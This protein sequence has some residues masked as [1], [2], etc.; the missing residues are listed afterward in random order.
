[1]VSLSFVNSANMKRLI[2]IL[3]ILTLL[4]GLRT[5]SDAENAEYIEYNYNSGDYEYFILTDG[6]AQISRYNGDE[7]TVYIPETINGIKVTA[8]GRQAFI[9]CQKLKHLIIPETL[10]R[11][12]DW[13]INACSS[14]ETV[15]L[16]DNLSYMGEN[17][18]AGCSKLTSIEISVENPFFAKID[19]ALFSKT[20]KRL[21][22]YPAGLAEEVYEIPQGVRIIGGSAFGGCHSLETV[23]IPESVT[24]IGDTAFMSCS[25][26]NSISIPDSVTSVGANPFTLCKNLET[27]DITPEQTYLAIIDH[28]LFSKPDKRLIAYP[29]TLQEES[30]RIPNGIL[31]VGDRAFDS[32]D[33]LAEISFPDS[34][35]Q[36]GFRAFYGATQL[37]HVVIPGRVESIGNMA[38]FRSG[39]EHVALPSG[40]RQLGDTAFGSCTELTSINIPDSQMVIG[41][42]PFSN[43]TSLTEFDVSESNPSLTVIEGALFSKDKKTLI[44]YP[45]TLLSES[46]SIPYGTVEIGGSAFSDCKNLNRV[47]IP[48]TVEFIGETAFLSSGVNDVTIPASV[49]YIGNNAFQTFNDIFFTVTRNSYAA[50]YCKTRGLKYT[51]VDANDWLLDSY[52][53]GTALIVNKVRYSPAQVN[54]YYGNEYLTM[55]NNYGSYLSYLGLDTSLGLAGLGDQESSMGDGGTWKDYFRD[56]AKNDIRQI[57]ALLD[58]AAEYGITLSEEEIAEVNKSF[59]GM[60]E[61]AKS[62][63][64]ASADEF[65]T[66]NY[67]VGVTTKIAWQ[68]ALDQALASKAYNEKQD[69]LS[70]TAEELEEYYQGLNGDRDLFDYEIYYVSAQTEETVTDEEGNET[71][72]AVANGE[73]RAEA[74]A[75]ADAIVMAYKDGDDIENTAERFDAAVSSQVEGAVPTPRSDYYG[76]NIPEEYAEWVKDTARQEGDIEVFA[77]AEEEASGYTVVLYLDRNDNHY[78]TANVRHILIKAEADE[79]GNYTDEAKEAAKARA[80]EILAEFEAGEKTEDSFAALAEQYSEDEGSNTNGGLYENIYQGQMVTEFNDFCFGGHEPGDTGIVYGESGS[81]AGYHVIYYVGDG[82]LYSDYL[83]E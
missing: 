69:S 80:E 76:S 20:D 47:V 33:K 68:A 7:E 16:P 71:V 77:D 54:Y 64:Y 5:S 74:K 65:Y 50:E 61:T 1:M 23:I 49:I 60:D 58:Y 39:L 75:A 78:P 67:G 36:I 12:D 70:W 48:E 53:T 73:T 59:E 55:V 38:F 57:R 35:K 46:Y 62:L 10:E 82:Q 6:T 51:Y 22:C 4:P 31:I 8:I 43:C 19:E 56:A 42:N 72:N 52:S 11:L 3:L 37:K 21:I 44:C 2:S 24:T 14:L 32:C 29:Y 63:G 27:I 28:V 66:M 15:H 13:A 45:A 41:S 18:F 26:L 17:P 81:Y 34:L 25:N 79:E 83:A 9:F 40:L 30:Y